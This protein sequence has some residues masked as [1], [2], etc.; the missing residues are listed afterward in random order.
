LAGAFVKMKK[1]GT[2]VIGGVVSIVR[3]YDTLK[4]G[5]AAAFSKVLIKLCKIFI[6]ATLSEFHFI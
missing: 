6:F 2:K 4:L 3:I 1:R 5:V